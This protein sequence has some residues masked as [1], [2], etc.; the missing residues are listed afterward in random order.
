MQVVG[1]GGAVVGAQRAV[2]HAAGPALRT[3]QVPTQL[4]GADP[5]EGEPVV[6]V[7]LDPRTPHSWDGIRAELR[8]LAMQHPLTQGIKRFLPHRKFP[9][10]IRHNAKIRREDLAVEAA[11]KLRA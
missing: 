5:I 11:R 2:E 9:V 3:V 7:E 6:L 1:V 8:A 10:D 4:A